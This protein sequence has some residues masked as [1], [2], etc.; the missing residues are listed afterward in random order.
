[1]RDVI[2]Y[3]FVSIALVVIILYI[4]KLLSD[5]FQWCTCWNAN[6]DFREDVDPGNW[7]YDLNG[8]LREDAGY[9]IVRI[10][11]APGQ[12]YDADQEDFTDWKRYDMDHN[13]VARGQRCTDRFQWCRC[14]NANRDFQEDVDPGNL[15]YDLNGNLREDAGY[16]IVRIDVAPGQNY[17]ADQ[18]DSAEWK[19]YDMDHKN[20]ARGQRWSV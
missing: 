9:D 14:W 18:E 7:G 11:V 8:N 2:I 4:F 19:H 16:D 12:N 10:D 3:I 20:V 17:D 13:N 15:G 1:M 6:R 5:R